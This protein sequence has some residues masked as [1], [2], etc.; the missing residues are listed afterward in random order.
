MRNPALLT[1]ISLAYLL[2]LLAVDLDFDLG[3]DEK[4]R[5]YY[6]ALTESLSEGRGLFRMIP[7]M[8]ILAISSVRS[9]LTSDSQSRICHIKSAT[10][11]I[12]LNGLALPMSFGA[13]NSACGR[14]G[15]M[16]PSNPLILSHTLILISILMSL[17]YTMKGESLEFKLK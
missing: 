6:C 7:F 15:S 14:A 17:S 10:V 4:A 9:I 16:W 2:G 5:A 1:L 13:V 8:M 3:P 11:V 12:L